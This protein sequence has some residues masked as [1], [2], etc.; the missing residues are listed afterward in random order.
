MEPISAYDIPVTEQHIREGSSRTKDVPIS[1]PRAPEP[2]ELAFGDYFQEQGDTCKNVDWDY[3][4]H[5]Y[6]V[7]DESVIEWVT[8]FYN[9]PPIT[10]QATINHKTGEGYM[11][12]CEYSNTRRP[13]GF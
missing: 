7:A 3:I 10:I 12:I 9:I 1:L 8:K 4:P 6:K 2:L 13:I 11:T 5:R